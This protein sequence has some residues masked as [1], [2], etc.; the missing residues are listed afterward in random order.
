MMDDADYYVRLTVARR[1]APAHPCRV[2]TVDLEVE[3][4]AAAAA[5]IHM[6]GGSSICRPITDAEVR[7]EAAQRLAP[8]QLGQL[9]DDADWRVRHHVAN[10]IGL[11]ELCRDARRS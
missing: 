9:R 8:S 2:R 4:A 1:I 6:R 3:V 5:R 7:L 10:Q 11:S